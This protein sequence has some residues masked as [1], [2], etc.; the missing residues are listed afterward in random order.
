MRSAYLHQVEH[1][2]P[3]ELIGRE[4]ELAE[5]KDFCTGDHDRT[6]LWWQGPPW[7]GKSALMATFVVHPP[8][9]V[10]VV[11]FFITNR[12]AGQDDRHAFVHAVIEQLAEL[13]GQPM[14]HRL[15]ATTQ[16]EWYARLL[17]EAAQLCRER[18]ERLILV[19]D[20]LDEDQGVRAGRSAHSI[21]ALLPAVPP[22]G[23]RVVVASRPNP[24]VPGDV[25]GRHP[26]RNPAIVRQLSPSPAAQ[27]IRDDAGRELDRLL[28]GDREGRDLL[29]FIV[30][31]GGGLSCGDLAELTG[32]APVEVDRRFA[33][34]AGA[35]SAPV[36][37]SGGTKAAPR[38][39]CWRMRSSTPP[40]PKPWANV[41][42]RGIGT[43]FMPGRTRTGIGAGR[44]G[45]P[46]ICCVVI[47]RCC[48]HLVRCRGRW[49]SRPT[50]GA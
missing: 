49:P 34:Y 22:H 15:S 17:E 14:P 6:Y 41:T 50:G 45:H 19:V 33:R 30:A 44:P 9:G 27:V 4:A 20:G 38:C 37:A 2:F 29:G 36:A 47:T 7:A 42:W 31:A 32:M 18:G 5:L 21:A 24:P 46:S 40:R 11:S 13:L 3:W 43:R 23:M 10:R 26:L 28:F 8:P 25:P 16:Q 12:F 1:I 48:A 35:A 39:T